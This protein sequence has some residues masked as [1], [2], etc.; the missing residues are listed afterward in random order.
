MNYHFLNIAVILAPTAFV[1][2]LLPVCN[3]PTFPG[4]G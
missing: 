4:L 1:I 2:L 3:C